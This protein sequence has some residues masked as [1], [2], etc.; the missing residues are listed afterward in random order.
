[1]RSFNS[2]RR[3]NCSIASTQNSIAVKPHTTKVACFLMPSKDGYPL[4][5]SDYLSTDTILAQK[6]HAAA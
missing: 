1:M 6:N 5:V 4:E 2:I 3:T